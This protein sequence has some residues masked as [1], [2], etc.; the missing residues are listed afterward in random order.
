[1]RYKKYQERDI[2]MRKKVRKGERLDKV[3][4]EVDDLRGN[5]ERGKEELDRHIEVHIKEDL[6][7]E[8]FSG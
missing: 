8:R 6:S 3:D 1:M 2:N 4:P 5:I 7:E